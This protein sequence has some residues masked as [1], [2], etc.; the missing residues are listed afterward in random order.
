V[1]KRIAG[2]LSRRQNLA[3]VNPNFWTGQEEYTHNCTNCVVAYELRRRGF[4]VEALPGSAMATQDL[5]D[6]FDGATIRYAA[7]LSTTNVIREMIPIIENDI[8][9]W[10]EGA[11]GVIRGEWAAYKWAHIFSL[12]VHDG[13]VRYDDGQTGR[14]N[15]KHLEN[16]RPLSIQYVRLDN[17]KPNNKVI[18]VVKNKE[19]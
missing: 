9:K 11:R 18:N 14:E 4:D 7:M 5:A 8:L 13:T 2:E 1:F 10:G 6:M 17:L 3:A 15:V 19:E 16:M 12:E